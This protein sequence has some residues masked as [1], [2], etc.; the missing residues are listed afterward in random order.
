MEAILKEAEDLENKIEV[1]QIWGT[2]IPF[3]YKYGYKLSKKNNIPLTIFTGEDYPLKKYNFINK[4]S[5]FFPIFRHKLYKNAKKAYLIS[6]A[7]IYASDELLEHYSNKFSVNKGKVIHFS[8]TLNKNDY[9]TTSENSDIIYGGNLYSDRCKSLIEIANHLR[10]SEIIN[11]YGNASEENKKLLSSIS[12]IK[13]FGVIDYKELI[14]KYKNGKL[15]I[16]I[17]G[18]SDDY[19]K[20]CQF[21]FSSKLSDYIVSGKPFFVYGPDKISGV[22]YIKKIDERIVATNISEL[23]KIDEVIKK[24]IVLDNNIV[25]EFEATYASNKMSGILENI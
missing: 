18:F 25:R 10:S 22:N 6:E 2:N 11:V 8:S 20:D 23:S 12:N 7:N 5:L 13:Y 14:K 21:A 3:L 9:K 15:L 17:E 16:H 1:I 4:F 24:S 19:I